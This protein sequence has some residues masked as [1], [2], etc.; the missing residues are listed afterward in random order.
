MGEEERELWSGNGMEKQDRQ[1]GKERK[2]R[3]IMNDTVFEF[4]SFFLFFSFLS[5]GRIRVVLCFCSLLCSW[6][7]CMMWGFLLLFPLLST[8]TVCLLVCTC[9]LDV[10]IKGDYCIFYVL[11]CVC[12]RLAR[13]SVHAEYLKCHFIYY[14]VMKVGIASG[15]RMCPPESPERIM[16]E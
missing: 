9:L 11:C 7:I 15:R 6:V 14:Q 13:W 5:E 1:A 16:R 8:T 4:F 12:A 2:G 3:Y 10:L